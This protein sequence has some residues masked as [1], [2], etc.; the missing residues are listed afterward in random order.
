MA[1]EATGVIMG[2]RQGGGRQYTQ[3]VLVKLLN[4][5][6]KQA[7]TFVGGIAVYRDRH[8]NTYKGR[9]LRLHGRRNAVVEVRFKPH[10]PGQAI[11]DLVTV[12]K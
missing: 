9:V 11:G 6:P 5:D 1:P 8:G 4:V 3:S 2:Y 10:L 7:G 12:K